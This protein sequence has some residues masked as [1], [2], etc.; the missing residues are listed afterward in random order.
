MFGKHVIYANSEFCACGIPKFQRTLDRR[1]IFVFT[2]T[3]ANK[4]TLNGQKTIRLTAIP[5]NQGSI[6]SF[7]PVLCALWT[8]L[9]PQLP[10]I[11]SRHH[12][13][14]CISWRLWK[15]TSCIMIAR[16]EASIRGIS[17]VELCY[18]ALHRRDAY[19]MCSSGRVVKVIWAKQRAWIRPQFEFVAFLY[20]WSMTSG[21]GF[22]AIFNQQ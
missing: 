12:Q 17:L 2:K 19:S 18:T 11:S 22:T 10:A 14:Y 20:A 6:K 4:N 21:Q 13:F 3:I 16:C 9:S 5:K 15:R 7:Q 8:F 1:I